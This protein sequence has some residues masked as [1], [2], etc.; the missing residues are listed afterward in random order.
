MNLLNHRSRRMK[1]RAVSLIE[2]LVASGILAFSTTGIIAGLVFN[3]RITRI[4]TNAMMAKNIAQGYFEQMNADTFAN[5]HPSNYPDKLES[6][7]TDPVWLDRDL[8][9]Q[10]EVDFNL[11]GFGRLDNMTGDS[12]TDS[13]KITG[14]DDWETNE[15]VGS[16]VYIVE[17]PGRGQFRKI[18]SNTDDTLKLGGE[19]LSP[20]PE[21]QDAYLINFGKTVEITTRWHYVRSEPYVQSVESLIVNH[22]MEQDLGF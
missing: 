2:V 13:T 1:R 17:G 7:E 11:N 15:W 18:I 20:L 22:R 16:Y 14:M 21:D 19:P 3:Y 10:C 12:L 8:G 4:N 9:I 6:D 5:I